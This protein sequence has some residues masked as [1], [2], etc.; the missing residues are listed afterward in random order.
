MTFR[1][2]VSFPDLSLY[3]KCHTVKRFDEDLRSLVA[4]MLDT[5]NVKNGV[6]LAANQIGIRKRVVVLKIGA[7]IDDDPDQGAESVPLVM[8]NPEITPV[9]DKTFKWEEACLSVPYISARVERFMNIQVAFQDVNGE[10][11]SLTADNELAGAIQHE[12]DHLDG[13][14]FLARLGRIKRDMLQRK[15]KKKL[16]KEKDIADMRA[17]ALKKE[18]TD[19]YGESED[20]KQSTAEAVKRLKIKRRRAKEKKNRKNKKRRK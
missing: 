2:I 11:H 7:L 17:L 8:V 4:D 15:I 14:L 6:G 20:K 10:K 16:K 1:N 12:C 3:R 5:M 9:G 13:K 19:I 18:M